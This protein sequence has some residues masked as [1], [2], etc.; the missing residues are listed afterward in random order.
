MEQILLDIPE[1]KERKIAILLLDLIEPSGWIN[2][3]WMISVN[4]IK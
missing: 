4:K 2:W 3:K 1:L